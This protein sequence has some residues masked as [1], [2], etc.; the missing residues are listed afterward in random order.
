[1]TWYRRIAIDF[2]TFIACPIIGGLLGYFVGWLGTRDAHD[3]GFLAVWLGWLGF[4]IGLLSGAGI[5]FYRS[6]RFSIGELRRARG[7][8]SDLA[9][10]RETDS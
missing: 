8:K 3:G 9:R 6:L 5:A 7:D 1:M 10:Q 2:V 4:V